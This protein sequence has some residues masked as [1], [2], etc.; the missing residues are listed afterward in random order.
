MSVKADY[1]YSI[2]KHLDKKII[3]IE[4]RN[5]GGMSVTN[6]IE[7]IVNEICKD[8]NIDCQKCIILY[9][10]STGLWDGWDC[11]KN[12]FIHLEG[13]TWKEAFDRM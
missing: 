6:C 1:N 9:K 5:L 11:R 2:Q 3:L 4:D 10:D 7:S 12:E 8:R 13:E